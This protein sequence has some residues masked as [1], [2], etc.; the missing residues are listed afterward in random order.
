MWK[1][2]GQRGRRFRLGTEGAKNFFVEV[3]GIVG[4]VRDFSW[5]DALAWQ[6]L[7]VFVRSHLA[8]MPGILAAKALVGSSA[9]CL[10][11]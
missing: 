9:Y 6:S 4:G 7:Q 10:A 8:A 11:S 2:W 3:D 5:K 1:F